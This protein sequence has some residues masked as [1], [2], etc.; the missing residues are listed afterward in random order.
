MTIGFTNDAVT[1]DN[2]RMPQMDGIEATT[3]LVQGG[4]RARTLT[5]TTF[6]LDEY[7]YHALTARAASC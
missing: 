6:N 1:I 3:R 7:I 4:A 5:L 2:V